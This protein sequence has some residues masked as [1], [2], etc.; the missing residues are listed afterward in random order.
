MRIICHHACAIDLSAA[1]V[2]VAR[3]VAFITDQTRLSND[4]QVCH[5]LIAD[6]LLDYVYQGF[7]VSVMGP[8]LHQVRRIRRSEASVIRV[9]PRSWI[10]H[11]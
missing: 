2:G 8:A 11:F 7:L 6:Q 3:C 9:Q 5:P 1:S 4:L 10:A